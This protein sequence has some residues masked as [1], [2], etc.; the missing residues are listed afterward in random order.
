MAESREPRPEAPVDTGDGP[1]R[2]HLSI[3][4]VLGILQDD[5][6]DIT[7]SKIRFLESQGLLNPERTPSGYRKFYPQDVEQLRWVLRQQKENFLPLK[8][9]KD[10]LAAGQVDLP[11]EASGL[12]DLAPV[13]AASNHSGA[14]V[15][16]AGLAPVPGDGRPAGASGVPEVSAG[17][18]GGS[19]REESGG[20][21]PTPRRRAPRPASASPA[22]DPQG[23]SQGDESPTPGAEP[24]RDVAPATAGQE[25][26]ESPTAKAAPGR[27]GR[28]A[29]A[30]SPDALLGA[31]GT[32]VSM[33][34]SELCAAADISPRFLA[35]LERFGLVAPASTDGAV[36]YDEEAL[37]T[38]RLAGAL[39]AFGVEPRHLR[40]YRV[41]AEREA[42]LYEQLIAARLQ[43]RRPESRAEALADL[44]RIN[45]L[46]G[47]FREVQL[48]SVLGDAF[49]LD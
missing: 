16:P 43:T 34:A 25:S 3:G 12:L 42:G 33:A 49:R 9:I 41:A 32:S 10:R 18:S 24:S 37:A 29:R 7:I 5:Y 30:G 28:T 17:A 11:P 15:E 4:E 19:A 6:P 8:V 45:D 27:R 26:P 39:G 21:G 31:A 48:R 14:A 44:A 1:V 22:A 38:A 47:Q 46:A 13:D 40:M 35:D 20:S 2:Q 23:G 36:T